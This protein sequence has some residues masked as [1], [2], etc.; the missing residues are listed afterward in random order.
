M[1][2]F[3]KIFSLRYAMKKTAPGFI[4]YLLFWSLFLASFDKKSDLLLS[5]AGNPLKR[6]IITI[7][8]SS[9]VKDNE[10][11]IDVTSERFKFDVS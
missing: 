10:I 2:F 1:F 8:F 9:D 11:F 4:C 5:A 3:V 7:K 6:P